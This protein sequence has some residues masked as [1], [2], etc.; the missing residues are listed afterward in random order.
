MFLDFKAVRG[1]RSIQ[2]FRVPP[3]ESWVADFGG[4][5]LRPL[6]VTAEIS[7]QPHRSYLVRLGVHD[8]VEAPCRRCLSPV[9]QLVEERADLLYQVME[10][11]DP[12]RLEAGDE[13]VFPLRSAFD[14]VDISPRVRETLLLAVERFPLCRP[15]CRGLCPECGQDLN[16]AS[17]SCAPRSGD[18]R[19]QP[20]RDLLA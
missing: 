18:P 2:S 15:E 10:P 9:R 12:R 13:E 16:V 14:R 8:E 6:D 19:W 5:L 3:D 1:G 4:R 17:C 7:E 11:G 20:L